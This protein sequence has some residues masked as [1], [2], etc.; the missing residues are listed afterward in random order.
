[1][2]EYAIVP[3]SRRDEL[4]LICFRDRRLTPSAHALYDHL[5]PALLKSEEPVAVK[6]QAHGS[7]LLVSRE[8][9]ALALD[10]LVR[11]RYLQ[12]STPEVHN[13]RRFRLLS[14]SQLSEESTQTHD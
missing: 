7:A 13:V 8:T 11:H 3:M 4:A 6:T 14:S 9:I 5:L 10:A 12:E 2:I 1:M